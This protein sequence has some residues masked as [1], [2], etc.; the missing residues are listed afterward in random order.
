VVEIKSVENLSPVHSKQLLTYLRFLNLPPGLLIN[1]G[2]ATFK[3]GVKRI[4]NNH[5]NFAFFDVKKR[6]FAHTKKIYKRGFGDL[7]P[8]FLNSSIPQ[9]I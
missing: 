3:E 1:F 6:G 9:S 2:S 7:I 8:Q 4:V 5:S